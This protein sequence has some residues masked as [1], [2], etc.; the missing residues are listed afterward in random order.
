MESLATPASQRSFAL[1]GECL[2][3]C[4]QPVAT[5]DGRERQAVGCCSNGNRRV[6]ERAGVLRRT[7]AADRGPISGDGAR[8][9]QHHPPGGRRR[10]RDHHT[11]ERA[12]DP[13]GAIAGSGTRSGLHRRH[14]VLQANCIVPFG[15]DGVPERNRE[16]TARG[17]Q[18][19][20]RERSCGSADA[21]QVAPGRRS[22][23]HRQ[24]ASRSPD[25]GGWRIDPEATML[26]AWRKGALHRLR[27]CRH[28]HHRGFGRTRRDDPCGTAMHGSFARAG[29]L[30]DFRRLSRCLDHGAQFHR[31]RR[32]LRSCN[33]DGTTDRRGLVRARRTALSGCVAPRRSSVAGPAPARPP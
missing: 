30:Q 10:R 4:G 26:G 15:P 29:R 12:R 31:R 17:H 3:S 13:A 27:R 33:A 2:G 23:V 32:R 18:Q 6:R 11:L 7:H 1:R 9:A 22:V 25:H 24:Y 20:R 5:P 8:C 14:Q 19:L 21:C 16:H 28:R